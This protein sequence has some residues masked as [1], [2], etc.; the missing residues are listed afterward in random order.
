M[1]K[2]K[3]TIGQLRGKVGGN[4][5]RHDPS[6]Y[7]VM[8]EYNPTPSNPRTLLQTNQRGKM[9]LAGQISKYVPY[10]AI[11]GMG[12]YP[13]QSRAAFV[14]NLLRNIHVQDGTALIDHKKVVFSKGVDKLV[15]GSISYVENTKTLTVTMDAQPAGTDILFYR[16]VVLLRE[17]TFFVGCIW[18]DSGA[19]VAGSATSIAIEIPNAV[20]GSTNYGMYAYVV[21][22]FA[23][24]EGVRV[25]YQDFVN[26]SVEQ[27]M[28]ASFTRS[29]ASAEAFAATEYLGKEEIDNDM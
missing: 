22:V 10:D 14:S 26:F 21:P 20:S 28:T 11:A 15:Q 6:G 1:A 16:V 3:S 23:S 5:F 12:G 7:T 19:V 9:N 27:K 17:A 25:I 8:S 13:R 4:V 2:V 29:L 24:T 18:Q